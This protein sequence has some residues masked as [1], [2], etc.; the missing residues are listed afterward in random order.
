MSIKSPLSFVQFARQL[1]RSETCGNPHEELAGGEGLGDVVVGPG[2]QTFGSG[3]LPGTR[4]Q[5]HNG[6]G[7]ESRVASHGPHERKSVE[8]GHHHVAENE[9]RR[10]P[11]NRGERAFSVA[12]GFHVPVLAKETG[13]V[14]AHVGVVVGDENARPRARAAARRGERSR[15]RVVRRDPAQCFFD[16]RLCRD[17][18][19]L[20]RALGPDP[21]LGQVV[22]AEGHPDGKRGPLSLLAPYSNVSPVEAH[23][24]VHER[25]ADPGALVAA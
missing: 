18:G 19:G 17:R 5:K 21:I 8:S 13:H 6:D 23:E 7:S 24:L 1:R 16:V 14:V 15:D 25:E 12:D 4:R 3:F 11:A 9:V 10:A 20:E 2:A 22:H